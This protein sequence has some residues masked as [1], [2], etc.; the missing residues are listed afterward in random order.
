M[1]I[2]EQPDGSSYHYMN[3]S[4]VMSFANYWSATSESL[5]QIAS[6]LPYGTTYK[7]YNGSS[8]SNNSNWWSAVTQ[9]LTFIGDDTKIIRQSVVSSNSKLNTIADYI[10]G[11]ETTLYTISSRINT[12][13]SSLNTTNSHLDSIKG[14]L[15]DLHDIF[16]NQTDLTIKNNQETNVQEATSDFFSGSASNTSIGAGS[17]RSV[18][19][20]FSDAQDFF[21]MGEGI[22]LFGALSDQSSS[23]PWSWYSQDVKNDLSTV[24]SN[25]G[26][27]YIDFLTPKYNDL[28]DRLGG[29]EDDR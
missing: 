10:D 12:T 9:S 20:S 6:R 13:N 25:R 22:D 19:G 17:I 7:Y 21:G 16:A 14:F 27:Y 15:S 24:Q 4:N 5:Y 28:F 18:K 2:N 29:E 8:S 1:A 11:I 26:E 23:G 3:G